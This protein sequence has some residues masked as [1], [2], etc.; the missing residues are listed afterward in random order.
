MKTSRT[1]TSAR[2]RCRVAG[3]GIACSRSKGCGRYT[4]PPC[5]RIAV[6][7]VSE[8]HAA[9]DLLLEEEA[10]HLSLAV[11][12][13][14]LAGYDDQLAAPC[15]L[16]GLECPA[17]GVVVGDRDCSEPDLLRVVEELRDRDR[18]VVRPVRVHVQIDDDPVPAGERIVVLGAG[19]AAASL[20]GQARVEPVELR[21]DEVE[22]LALGLGSTSRCDPSALAGV[23]GE[24]RDVR[25]NAFW[26]AS[27]HDG[28]SCGSSLECE[29][30]LAFR[31]GDEDRC[32]SQNR[33]PLVGSPHEADVRTLAHR[34]W[35][36]GPESERLRMQQHELPVG[37]VSEERRDRPGD[38]SSRQLELD[39]DRRA[40]SHAGERASYRRRWARACS[41]PRSAPR[42]PRRFPETSQGG[43]R[44]ERG[45]G[46]A[47][48]GVAGRQAGRE[49]R[50]SPLSAHART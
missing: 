9:G 14:L 13:D 27:F 17:E 45:A 15:E 40:V 22:A 37:K 46:R 21:R 39:S 26:I 47:A 2:W 12:L 41:R 23:G 43:R 24:L 29:P 32:L 4:S 36:R 3:S 8:G 19:V 30:L 20:A 18:A 44:R 50:T 16:D 5:S 38:A 25:G 1:S 11:G 49:R 42:L 7:R 33:S 28:D 6:D 34:A 48:S 10:D 35:D 31:G